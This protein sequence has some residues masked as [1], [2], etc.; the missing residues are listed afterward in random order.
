MTTIDKN[1]RFIYALGVAKRSRQLQD[2]MPALIQNSLL[3]VVAM[4]KKEINS[5]AIN[6]EF[7]EHGEPLP[8]EKEKKD[9][10]SKRGGGRKR[11]KSS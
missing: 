11:K 2:G 10:K 5:G 1:N 7:V 9:V 8:Q 6:V 3:N 4:A